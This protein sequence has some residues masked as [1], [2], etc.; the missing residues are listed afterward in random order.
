MFEDTNPKRQRGALLNT[1]PKQQRGTSRPALSPSLTLRVC[2]SIAVAVC[3]PSAADE[4]QSAAA[5]DSKGKPFVAKHCVGC[6]GPTKQKGDRRFDELT[7]QIAD[8]NGLV[9]LQDIVD[10]LNLGE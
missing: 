2:L 7:G 3:R 4:L 6:H 5:F 9:D 10:Q 8:D 1:S